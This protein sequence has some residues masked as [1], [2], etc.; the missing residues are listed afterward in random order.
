MTRPAR[1]ALV[2]GASGGLG[3]AIAIRLA[4]EGWHLVLTGRSREAL[5]ETGRQMR[6]V[7]PASPARVHPCDLADADDV[8]RLVREI[9]A[10]DAGPDALVNNAA[11]QGPIG[12]F[13]SVDWEAWVGTLT[14]DLIAPA[15]LTQ[16]LLP[17]MIARGF[18]RIINISGG[19]ATGPR[20]DFSAYSVAKTGIVRFTETLA[21]ELAGTGVTVNAVAP[22]PMNTRMLDEVLR[23]GPEGARR[24][25]AAAAARAKDGGVPPAD[26]ARLIGWL[27]SDQ[28]STITGRLLSAVWDR[29]ETLDEHA[30]MLSG[31]DIYTLRRIVPKDRGQD[32]GDR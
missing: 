3:R 4:E 22:G 12:P 19:G 17:R 27:V 30:A 6:A 25:H 8:Q 7:A 24:E 16:L 2:T 15:R 21:V 9:A 14:L 20:P 23:A 28:A 18:G 10:D 32:W 11:V 1:V 26:A 13:I 5:D 31:S 29:W